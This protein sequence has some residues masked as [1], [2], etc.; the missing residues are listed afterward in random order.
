MVLVSGAGQWC[1]WCWPAGAGQWCCPVLLSSLLAALANQVHGVHTHARTRTNVHTNALTHPGTHTQT[2]SKQARAH[3]S[4]HAH[5]RL[6]GL[7]FDHLRGP[8]FKA[9]IWPPNWPPKCGHRQSVATL[10]R[11][12][13][14]PDY[15]PK[16]R[17]PKIMK[18][19]NDEIRWP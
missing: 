7:F 10:W 1:E 5:T 16:T 4:T 15:G 13:R 17:T 14:R 2:Q 3:T 9:R 6:L 12:V 11:P 8:N 18:I 19:T